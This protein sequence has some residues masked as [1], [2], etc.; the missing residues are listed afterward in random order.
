MS[1]KSFLSLAL[2]LACTLV[3]RADPDPASD[4]N[5]E[6][7][8]DSDLAADP[9]SSMEALD[10]RA[11]QEEAALGDE[12]VSVYAGKVGNADALFFITWSSTGSPVEGRYYLPVRGKNVMYILKGTNPKAGVLELEEFLDDGTGTL[13]PNA[14]CTMKK[15]TADGR[16]VWEGEKSYE[17]GNLVTMSFSRA[18]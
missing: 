13:V 8:F 17:N 18:K 7:D 10:E 6:P 5:P 14:T 11:R 15:K 16:I 3:L 1:P 4:P 9:V 12:T 2:V